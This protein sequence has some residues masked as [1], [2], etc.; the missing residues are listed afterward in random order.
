MTSRW[1]KPANK[2]SAVKKFKTRQLG[3]FQVAGLLF[4]TLLIITEQMV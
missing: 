3:F 2:S 1:K 4:Y